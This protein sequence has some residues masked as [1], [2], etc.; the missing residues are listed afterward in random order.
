MW[1]VRVDT[2]ACLISCVCEIFRKLKKSENHDCFALI[3][4]KMIFITA[5]CRLLS[6]PAIVFYAVAVSV[7]LPGGL[8]G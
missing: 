8:N 6:Y 4:L 1:N 5:A 7:N 2:V 3:F